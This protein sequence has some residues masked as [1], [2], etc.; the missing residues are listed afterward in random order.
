M[1]V[2]ME[3]EIKTKMELV[4]R[5]KSDTKENLFLFRE[6]NTH[7]LPGVFS[8]PHSDSHLLYL[9][10]HNVH[11]VH[12][13]RVQIRFWGNFVVNGWVPCHCNIDSDIEDSSI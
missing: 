12:H 6:I 13:D 7:I 8:I 10:Y 2:L 4:Y 11:G 3:E 1:F 9:Q 5:R